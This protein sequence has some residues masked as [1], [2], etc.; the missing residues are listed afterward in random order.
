MKIILATRTRI[1]KCGDTACVHGQGVT[2][3]AVPLWKDNIK[4]EQGRVSSH[5]FQKKEVE[6]YSHPYFLD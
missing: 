4:E 2:S 1:Q 3:E 6:E 5:K